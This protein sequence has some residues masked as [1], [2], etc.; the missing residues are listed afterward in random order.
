MPRTTIKILVL[1]DID[2]GFAVF[3]S[4]GILSANGIVGGDR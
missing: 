2:F 4:G 1:F 3:I